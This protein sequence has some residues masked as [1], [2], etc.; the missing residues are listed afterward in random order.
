MRETGVTLLL[1]AL[2]LAGHPGFCSCAD[3]TCSPQTGQEDEPS[4]SHQREAA[5][6]DACCPHSGDRPHGSEAV[7]RSSDDAGG[8]CQGSICLC[9]Y[10]RRS[11][12]TSDLQKDATSWNDSHFLGNQAV[13]SVLGFAFA[14]IPQTYDGAK[15]DR[16]VTPPY[17]SNHQILC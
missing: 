15:Q 4:F 13:V 5:S 14:A 3:C 11:A 17:L 16:L 7:D 10:Q 6:H 2:V 12:A 1:I 8:C 9:G